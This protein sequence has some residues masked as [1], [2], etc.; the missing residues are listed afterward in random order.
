[1]NAEMN[2]EQAK[3][4]ATKFTRRW[5]AFLIRCILSEEQC[6]RAAL[7]DLV[8]GTV[9]WNGEAGKEFQ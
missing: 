6:Y 4:F 2:Q 7:L 8:N 1:M 5:L 3:Y 9:V